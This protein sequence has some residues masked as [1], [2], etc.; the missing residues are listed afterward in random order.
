MVSGREIVHVSSD[1]GNIFWCTSNQ[2]R[3]QLF[4]R[5]FCFTSPREV[6]VFHW[7]VHA[8][9]MEQDINVHGLPGINVSCDLHMEHLN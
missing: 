3:G 1:T 5:S 4:Y 2:W 7:Y 9:E 8:A 6:S